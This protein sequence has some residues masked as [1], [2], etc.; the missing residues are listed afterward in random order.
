[1]GATY[2]AV[3]IR[4][5]TWQGK[6]LRCSAE[7]LRRSAAKFEG[8]AS[9]LN[10]LP[11]VPGQHGYPMLERLAGV[12][13]HAAWD[14]G[15][16]AVV[17]DYRL[18][19]TDAARTVGRLIDGWLAARAAGRA[20]AEIGLS[21][22]PWVRLGPAGPDG[23]REVLEIVKVDQVDAVYRPAAGGAFTARLTDSMEGDNMAHEETQ[24][25]AGAAPADEAGA[26]Q[27]VAL[28]GYDSFADTQPAADASAA[29]L[30]GALRESLLEAR[31]AASGLPG[32]FQALVRGGLPAAWTAAELDARIRQ[33]R[34]AWAAEE[35]RHAVQGTRPLAG[36]GR[37]TGMTSGLD[38]VTEALTALV[39]GRSPRQGV[40]RLSGIREAYLLLSG[41]REMTG[42]FQA[43]QVMLANVNSTTMANLVADVLNKVISRE[44]QQYPRWWEGFV[45]KES[46][47]SLQ[48]VKWV[49]LGGVGELPAVNEGAAYTEL[50]WD[51][52]RE[53]A[54]WQKRG[55]YLGLT[56]EAIDKDDT[57]RLRSA[58]R[59]LA[60]AAWLT[61]GKT[62]S[63]IFT[64][65]AGVGPNMSD[66]KALFHADHHNLGAAA[67][68]ATSWAAARLAMRQQ[69][70]LHSGE[71]LGWLTTPRFLL[72]PPELEN[73]A[74]TLLASEN[75]PGTANNDINP[76]AEGSTRDARLDAARRRIVVVDLWTDTNNWAAAADPRLYPTIG[77]GF[78]YGETPELFSVASPTSGLMF[79]NDVL[80][81]KV[82]WV[83]AAGPQDYRGL[84]KANVA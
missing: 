51:D 79:T 13:E 23:L 31:L 26:V 27:R 46:F 36:E 73:A 9:F 7:V 43:E 54:S 56:L 60:Q 6:G 81:I 58:P 80:P 44:F 38:Q 55:G 39:E 11:P 84:Y 19:D 37:L 66:G 21:A 71:R 75:L 29:A 69:T 4:P 78:R 74:L 72:V 30:V 3:L 53:T 64:A 76:E 61:L 48:D 82:R 18:A 12:V 17:A 1:M 14:A 32:P 67:L 83:Y 50:T 25:A 57:A 47:S 70:E 77:L 41:D 45:T 24:L 16:N 52:A 68:D 65:N 33:V 42:Q 28:T 2:R 34:A 63:A 8:L 49:L 10:P 15:L 22:V 40:A 35:G 20:A 5:G 62:I 59:A